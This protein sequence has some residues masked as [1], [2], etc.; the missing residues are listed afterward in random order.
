[1]ACTNIEARTPT[2][3]TQEASKVEHVAEMNQK[4]QADMKAAC[5]KLIAGFLTPST[6]RLIGKEDQKGMRSDLGS[7]FYEAGELSYYIW[8]Q[9]VHINIV[10]LENLPLQLVFDHRSLYIEAHS[11]HRATLDEDETSLDGREILQMLHPAIVVFGNSDGADYDK[12]S[13]WKKAVVWMGGPD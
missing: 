9:K 7:I 1:M 10:R 13:V 11:S 3:N 12:M 4:A 5:D 6:R 8:T 2:S